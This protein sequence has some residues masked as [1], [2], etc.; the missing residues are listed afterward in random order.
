MRHRSTQEAVHHRR[1]LKIAKAQCQEDASTFFLRMIA[2][3][4]ELLSY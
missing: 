2:L 1:G 3:K 4:P